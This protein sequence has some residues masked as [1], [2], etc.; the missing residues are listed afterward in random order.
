MTALTETEELM[1]LWHG[2]A[3]ADFVPDDA[4]RQAMALQALEAVGVDP[5]DLTLAAEKLKILTLALDVVVWR[6]IEGR[7][8]V[9]FDF[10]ADG[11]SFSRSQ[12]AKTATGMRIRAENAA[13][14]AG[15]T[16]LG[17]EVPIEVYGFGPARVPG[18]CLEEWEV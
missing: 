8:A 14:N 15:L 7:V 1:T 2:A 11:A 16:G 3:L 10:S 5:T 13:R 18:T 4:L 17:D 12:L 9:L 6:Y